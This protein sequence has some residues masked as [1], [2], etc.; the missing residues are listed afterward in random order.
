[1]LIED[2]VSAAIINEQVINAA[3][4]KNEIS[5]KFVDVIVIEKGGGGGEEE[6]VT[7]TPFT[8]NDL[9]NGQL[10]KLHGL[11]RRVVSVTI[12][13]PAGIEFEARVNNLNDNT[14]VLIEL[15]RFEPLQGTWFLTIR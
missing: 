14:R 3:I 5:A 1:M 4:V 12:T 9:V 2:K 8:Q 11:N 10:I 7:V 6:V 15:N 13:N